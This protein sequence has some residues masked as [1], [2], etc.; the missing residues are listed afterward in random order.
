MCRK[1]FI[2]YFTLVWKVFFKY[3]KM[4][5]EFLSIGNRRNNSNVNRCVH[6]VCIACLPKE[7]IYTTKLTNTFS[8]MG[9]CKY[10][11]H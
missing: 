10:K 8:S 4:L 2:Y 11:L 7:Y 5:E 3:V 6:P 9:V 1:G